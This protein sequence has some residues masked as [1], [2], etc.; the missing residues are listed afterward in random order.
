MSLFLLL[1]KLILMD[2]IIISIGYVIVCFCLTCA[3]GKKSTFVARKFF[4]ICMSCWWSIRLLF[5]NNDKLW[6]AITVFLLIYVLLNAFYLKALDIGVLC[7]LVVISFMT[8]I[9]TQFTYFVIPATSAMLILGFSDSLAALIGRGYQKH[10]HKEYKKSIIGTITFTF[11]S[12]VILESIC[13][14]YNLKILFVNNLIFSIILAL[15]EKMLFGKYDNIFIAF[16][17]FIYM[18]FIGGN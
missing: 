12:I 14:K 7:F 3:I 13:Y 10:Y 16:F 4:H 2:A 9:T 15:F 18:I 11:I 1:W 6:A 17:V 8:W 5:I